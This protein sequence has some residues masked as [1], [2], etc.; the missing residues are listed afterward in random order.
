MPP[1]SSGGTGRFEGV[2][3]EGAPRGGL[4]ELEQT[5]SYWVVDRQ[6]GLVVASFEGL[7]E[8]SFLVRLG[9]G[10]TTPSLMCVKLA[11]RQTTAR[12]TSSTMT[13]ERSSCLCPSSQPQHRGQW[14]ARKN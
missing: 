10:L 1:L 4:H 7:M 8:A 3:A 12:F 13:A 9:C 14:L 11:L 6:L 2:V 5:T